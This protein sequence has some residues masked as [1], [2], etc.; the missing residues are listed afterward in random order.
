MPS[1]VD[2]Q[3]RLLLVIGLLSFLLAGLGYLHPSFMLRNGTFLFGFLILSFALLGWRS[4]YTWLIRQPYLRERV[5]V[6]G[7]GYLADRVVETLRTRPE[8]GMDVAG[9]VGA[10]ANGS[11]GLDLSIILRSIKIVLLRRVT[12]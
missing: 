9:C 3:C 1:C 6:L 12:R 7:S 11:L 5:R 8:L 2:M 4:C 10:I